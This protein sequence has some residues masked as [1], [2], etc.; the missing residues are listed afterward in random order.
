MTTQIVTGL[1]LLVLPLGY[2]AAF[3]LLGRAF[4][5]PNILRR[6]T[7]QILRRF[8]AGTETSIGSGSL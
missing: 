4:N 5:Y 6:P 1:L 8:A 3:A 7:G 2:N